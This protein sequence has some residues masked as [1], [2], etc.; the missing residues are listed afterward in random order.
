MACE[1]SLC[2]RPKNDEKLEKRRPACCVVDS[3]AGDADRLSGV[4][5]A[6]DEASANEDQRLLWS[7]FCL[8]PKFPQS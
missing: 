4:L 8:W 1:I 5:L 3:K 6:T 7:M 2:F